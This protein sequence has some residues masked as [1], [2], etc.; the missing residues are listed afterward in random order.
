MENQSH[1]GL[2]GCVFVHPPFK[3]KG[4]CLVPCSEQVTMISQVLQIFKDRKIH[5]LLAQ[6]VPVPDHPQ[7]LVTRYQWAGLVSI[8]FTPPMLARSL[9]LL[10]SRRNYP[11]YLSPC[12]EERHNCGIIWVGK[13]LQDYQAQLP[14]FITE[15][16]SKSF[17]IFLAPHWTCSSVCMS[18]LYWWEGLDLLARLCLVCPWKAVVFSQGHCTGFMVNLLSTRKPRFFFV[19]KTFQS[20]LK[21]MQLK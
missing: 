21:N 1:Q 8:I 20:Y 17:I 3:M 19:Q 5:N 4:P 2:E 18:P 13:D 11:I 9:S 14:S 12:P 6:P 16:C 7:F 10:L 15:Q